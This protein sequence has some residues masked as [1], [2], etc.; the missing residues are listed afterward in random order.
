MGSLTFPAQGLVYLDAQG[1]IYS[2]EQHPVYQPLLRPLW[3]AVQA[4]RI[5]VV[6]SELTLLETLVKPLKDGNTSLV[7]RYEQVMQEPGIRLE[8]ITPLTLRE[9]AN[10]RAKH[11]ALRT[12]DA[13]HAATGLLTKCLQYISN[14]LRLRF[15]RGTL[16]LILL[17]DLLP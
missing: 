3:A 7:A 15:L 12:P 8:P 13:I 4:G 14:D 10:L 2:V 1:F 6:T 9:A 16:P 11:T 17:Q 5:E